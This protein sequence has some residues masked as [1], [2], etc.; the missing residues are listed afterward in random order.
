MVSHIFIFTLSNIKIQENFLPSSP[1]SLLPEENRIVCPKRLKVG[2]IYQKLTSYGLSN[3]T[4]ADT[5]EDC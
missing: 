3:V 4:P 5:L 2:R 1:V